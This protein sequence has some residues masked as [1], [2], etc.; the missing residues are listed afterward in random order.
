MSAAETRLVSSHTDA[1]GLPFTVYTYTSG[2]DTF[3]HVNE[4][5]TIWLKDDEEYNEERNPKIYVDRDEEREQLAMES[6]PDYVAAMARRDEITTQF[7]AGWRENF[8]MADVS[9]MPAPKGT[10]IHYG[11][12]L[13]VRNPA[14]RVP[15]PLCDLLRGLS[16]LIR[17][18][19]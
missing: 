6:H 16:V 15:T 17:K 4:R 12:H 14:E 8:V 3:P 18:A 7:E 9:L 11:L 1:L 5:F 19:S 2:D 13:F 10:D